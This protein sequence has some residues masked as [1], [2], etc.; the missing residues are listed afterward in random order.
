VHPWA[1]EFHVLVDEMA[2]KIEQL[3]GKAEAELCK[4]RGNVLRRFGRGLPPH[5]L[6]IDMA[7]HD[8]D[9]LRTFIQQYSRLPAGG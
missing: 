3:A 1:D 2:A 4:T 6:Y 9:Y 8:L 5:Q 7:I